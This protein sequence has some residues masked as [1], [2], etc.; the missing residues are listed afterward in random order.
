VP[1][2]IVDYECWRNSS[3]EGRGGLPSSSAHSSGRITV[4]RTLKIDTAA[5]TRRLA[6]RIEF[7][8]L[9]IVSKR[10]PTHQKDC[11]RVF[12]Y[13]GNEV[14]VCP[15]GQVKVCG[16]NPEALKDRFVSPNCPENSI[17]TQAIERAVQNKQKQREKRLDRVEKRQARNQRRLD[18]M[19]LALHKVKGHTNPRETKRQKIRN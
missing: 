14:I 10:L 4:G 16:P 6:I 11:G 15:N 9:Q 17:L 2:F 7:A 13:S 5:L 8:G 12:L 3:P 18:D 19:F 1:I